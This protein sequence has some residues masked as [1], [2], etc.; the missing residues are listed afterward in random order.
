M[1]IPPEFRRL[2]DEME[3]AIF[4]LVRNVSPTFTGTLAVELR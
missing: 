1:E 4:R 2:S 3:I